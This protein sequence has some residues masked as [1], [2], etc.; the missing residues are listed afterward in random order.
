MPSSNTYHLKYFVFFLCAII[1]AMQVPLVQ[2]V[3]QR[4]AE[5]DGLRGYAILAVLIYHCIHHFNFPVY[6]ENVNP[7]LIKADHFI[8]KFSS[9]FFSGKV[10]SIFALL[11]GLTFYIQHEKQRAQG[12]D[13]SNRFAW[14]MLLLFGFGCINGA[15]FPDGDILVL[16]SMIGILLIPVIRLKTPV[17]AV[18]AIFFLLQPI[19]LFYIFKLQTDPLFH[20][21][22]YYSDALKAQV[23]NVIAQGNFW[24]IMWTN[25]TK[26]QLASILWSF[27]TGRVSQVIGLYM[28]G[29]IAGRL[30][31]FNSSYYNKKFW[32]RVLFFVSLF[33]VLTYFLKRLRISHQQIQELVGV[34]DITYSLWLNIFFTFISIAAFIILYNSPLK[35]LLHPF[36]YSG[37]MSLTNYV[38]QSIIGTALFFPYGLGLAYKLGITQSFILS[39]AVGIF[40]FIFSKL[41]LSKFK[42]GPLEALWF[43]LTWALK[44]NQKK[45]AFQLFSSKTNVLAKRMRHSTKKF[46]PPS[47]TNYFHIS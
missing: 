44:K 8:E 25:L 17:L 5:V 6:P 10:Y 39:I 41:W 47:K 28:Y 29:I 45:E 31:V 15:F 34:I 35:K 7:L 11:F 43:R 30:G 9:L 21:P 3:K 24:E 20:I 18:L 23:N 1:K 4:F 16:Y 26:G 22:T 40:L 27:E 2:K 32:L 19:Q 46:M 36:T 42:Q 38:A 33:F 37:K 12:K 14:R 13:Y